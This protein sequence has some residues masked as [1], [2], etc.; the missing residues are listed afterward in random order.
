MPINRYIHLTCDEH[1]LISHSG[2]GFL[3]DEEFDCEVPDE[4]LD[5]R[6]S[7]CHS[8]VYCSVT[9]RALYCRSGNFRSH[10]FD[11][12]KVGGCTGHLRVKPSSQYDAGT[13][14]MYRA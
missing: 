2:V 10:K 1:A 4:Y 11:I 7:V 6:Y 12:F 13:S 3:Q 5:V 9:N 8:T 14:V